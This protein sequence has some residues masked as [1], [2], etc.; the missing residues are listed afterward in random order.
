MIPTPLEQF[1]ILNLIP[2]RLGN[3]YFSFTNFSLLN[4]LT[5]VWQQG[6]DLQ[7]LGCHEPGVAFGSRAAS[8]AKSL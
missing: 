8:E 7:R 3:V 2:I 1:S 6:I 4:A 5:A